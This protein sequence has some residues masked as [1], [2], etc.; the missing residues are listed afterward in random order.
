MIG[1]GY[2]DLIRKKIEEEKEKLRREQENPD[3]NIL[4]TRNLIILVIWGLLYKL[5]I[6]YEFGLV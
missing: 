5:F 2:D 6:K 3:L 1:E 4:T